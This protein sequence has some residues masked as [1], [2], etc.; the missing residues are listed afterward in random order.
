[1]ATLMLRG[2]LPKFT[3]EKWPFRY[4]NR[5][6]IGLLV[7]I[8]NQ[9]PKIDLC[10]KFQSNWRKDKGA[11]ISTWINTENCLMKSCSSH[12][13]DVAEIFMLL[14]DYV[15]EFH[16]A[17]FLANWTTKAK[18]GKEGTKRSPPPPAYILSQ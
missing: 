3:S 4:S 7:Q 14:R 16:H 9:A 6:H 12:E 11:R 13:D 5:F 1:M 10:P 8:Q 17:K 15:P 2:T 18:H